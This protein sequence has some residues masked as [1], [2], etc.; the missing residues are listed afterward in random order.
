MLSF[1]MGV[2]EACHASLQR[3]PGLPSLSRLQETRGPEAHHQPE[4]WHLLICP[5]TLKHLLDPKNIKELQR[6]LEYHVLN[7]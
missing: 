1:E 4:K 6:I 5:D 3:D 2:L 7:G